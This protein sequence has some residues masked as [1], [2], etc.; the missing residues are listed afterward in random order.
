MGVKV[1]TTAVIFYTSSTLHLHT[2]IQSITHEL[3]EIWATSKLAH[4]KTHTL[5]WLLLSKSKTSL[6]YPAPRCQLLST[7]DFEQRTV[8]TE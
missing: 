1:I 8:I 7:V 3:F 4:T 6:N 2:D 5:I